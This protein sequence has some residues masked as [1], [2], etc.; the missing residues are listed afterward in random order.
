MN[1]GLINAAELLRLPFTGS[2]PPHSL[3]LGR[4]HLPGNGPD[5]RHFTLQSE[6][7]SPRSE[8]RLHIY[9][10]QFGNEMGRRKYEPESKWKEIHN[11]GR[12]PAGNKFS[13]KVFLPTLQL[14]QA[15]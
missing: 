1:A 11:R 15:L 8:R 5:S 7:D 6:K 9:A 10:N 4:T 12:P 3:C 14:G 13:C 2:P